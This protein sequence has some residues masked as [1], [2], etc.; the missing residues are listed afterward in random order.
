MGKRKLAG[1]NMKYFAQTSLE[2]WEDEIQCRAGSFG[3]Q[4]G[5]QST[6]ELPWHPPG[7]AERALPTAQSCTGVKVYSHDF[8]CSEQGRR[9]RLCWGR[10]DF[11]CADLWDLE[12]P[13]QG[14]LGSLCFTLL[15]EAKPN[16]FA[17]GKPC[18]SLKGI[19]QISPSWAA[20][21]PHTF[22]PG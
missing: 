15:F 16:Q 10:T 3:M 12:K 20:E 11:P 1:S 4:P 13:P 2:A 5:Y 21:P 19:R 17:T 6:R 22:S 7:G 14:I 8:C 18:G 9:L